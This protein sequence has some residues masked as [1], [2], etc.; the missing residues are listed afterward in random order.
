MDDGTRPVGQIAVDPVNDF[1]CCRLRAAKALGPTV[2]L[3]IK[4]HPL[5]LLALCNV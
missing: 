5:G 2:R 1:K 4:L 3:I